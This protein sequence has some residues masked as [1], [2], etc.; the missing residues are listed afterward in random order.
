[1]YEGEE[2]LDFPSL[3]YSLLHFVALSLIFRMF[4]FLS[5]TLLYSHFLS[6]IYYTTVIWVTVQEKS[7]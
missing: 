5:F 6:I 2:A 1:M 4:S 7:S 3:L